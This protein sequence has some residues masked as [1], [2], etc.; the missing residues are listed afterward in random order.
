MGIKYIAIIGGGCGPDA[1]D[2]DIEIDA[3][4][5]EDAFTT[6]KSIVFDDEYGYGHCTIFSLSQED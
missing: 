3:D 4:D 1:W 6:L 2:K 5:F